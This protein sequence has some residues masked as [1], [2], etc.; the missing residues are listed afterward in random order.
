M[1]RLIKYSG[2]IFISIYVL[3]GFQHCTKDNILPSGKALELQAAGGM[4]DLMTD[5]YLWIDSMPIVNKQDYSTPE[6]MLDAMRYLPRDIWSYVSTLE[7]YRSYFEEGTYEGHGFSYRGDEQGNYW[8]LFVY[9]DSDLYSQG[10]RRGW[11]ILKLNG[12]SIP[13]LANLS[14]YMNEI[15]D[16]FLLLKPDGTTVE[17]SSSRKL[18]TINSVLHADTLHVDAKIVGHIVFNSFIGP[19]ISD[20]DSI[21]AS[22][23][24]LGVQELILDMRYNRGGRMDVAQKLASLIAGSANVDKA[25]VSYRYNDKRSDNNSDVKFSNE[26]NSLN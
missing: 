10:V 17:I 9:K 19:A 23:K 18:I 12:T 21:F 20:L 15:V 25:F 11:R 2:I 14:D 5:W 24:G 3:F 4:Y 8:I 13:P 26:I 1:K 16:V 22:F 6:S 7:E